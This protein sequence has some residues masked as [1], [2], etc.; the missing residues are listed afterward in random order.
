MYPSSRDQTKTLMEKFGDMLEAAAETAIPANTATPPRVAVRKSWDQ[1]DSPSLLEFM[2]EEA[3]GLRYWVGLGLS[4][5]TR[6]DP[7]KSSV[8]DI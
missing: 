1:W 8:V 6:P 7:R 3:S 2:I 5:P 4:E